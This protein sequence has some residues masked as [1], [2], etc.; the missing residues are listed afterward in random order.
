MGDVVSVS[1]DHEMACRCNRHPVTH[2][3]EGGCDWNP[4][5]LR[6]SFPAADGEAAI[7][8]KVTGQARALLNDHFQQLDPVILGRFLDLA[9][10]RLKVEWP[11][12]AASLFAMSTG[13]FELAARIVSSM[14]HIGTAVTDERAAERERCAMIAERHQHVNGS[15]PMAIAREIRSGK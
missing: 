12:Q 7:L 13:D 5:L 8:A 9:W 14:L 3:V 2:W 6:V 1:D 15:G 11:Y 4:P 10:E